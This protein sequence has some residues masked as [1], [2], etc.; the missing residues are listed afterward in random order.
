MSQKEEVKSVEQ[1]AFIEISFKRGYNM[2]PQYGS[3]KEYNFK[4]SGNQS[5]V[6]EQIKNHRARLTKYVKEVEAL[7][8]E[9]HRANIEKSAVTEASAP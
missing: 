2:G 9:A 5:I 4:I 1:E 8:E 7:I 6:E 3:V